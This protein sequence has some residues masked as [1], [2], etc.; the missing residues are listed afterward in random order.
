MGHVKLL[1]SIAS[2]AVLNACSGL[3]Y[4]S[5]GV[6]SNNSLPS[7]SY[8]VAGKVVSKKNAAPTVHAV[9]DT[10]AGSPTGK[11]IALTFDDGPRPY[12]L[13]GSKGLHPAPGLVDI[14]DKNGVKA[15]F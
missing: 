1:L 2:L 12:V 6:D 11:L 14:L 7:G 3:H 5:A 13:F 8:T 4:P 10:T 15:T 9:A